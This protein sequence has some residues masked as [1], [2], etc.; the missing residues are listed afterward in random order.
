MSVCMICGCE[1]YRMSYDGLEPEEPC[2]CDWMYEWGDIPSLNVFF[3]LKGEGWKFTDAFKYPTDLI[4][5]I[6]DWWWHV[7]CEKSARFAWFRL[8]IFRWRI[9]WLT[10]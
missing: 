7:D 4:Q 3:W 9:T 2:Y 10:R 5:E 1:F 6:K 8:T